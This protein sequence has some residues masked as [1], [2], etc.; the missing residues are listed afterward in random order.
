MRAKREA[1]MEEEEQV[2]QAALQHQSKPLTSMEEIVTLRSLVHRNVRRTLK[3]TG[4]MKLS[5]GQ[6]D[7]NEGSA[8]ESED[9]DPDLK[10]VENELLYG[11]DSDESYFEGYLK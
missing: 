6:K 11:S 1:M 2:F 8:E 3:Q 9:A 10:N 5:L 7:K 4:R